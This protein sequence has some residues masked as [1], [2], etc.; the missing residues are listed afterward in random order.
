MLVILRENVENLGRTGDVVR[1]S[2]GYARNFLLPN[3]LVLAANEA[4]LSAVENQK[5]ALQK[6]R[7]AEKAKAQGLADKLSSYRAVFSRKV[8]EENRLFGSVTT[9]DIATALKADGYQVERGWIQ[10]DHP[11][12]TLGD[13]DVTIELDNGVEATIKVTVNPEK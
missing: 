8:A 6:K 12:K 3:K 5:K 2:N 10:I 11:I 13:H 1:V 4:N 7:E 9:N